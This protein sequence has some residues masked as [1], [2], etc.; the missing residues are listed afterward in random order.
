MEIGINWLDGFYYSF[1]ESNAEYLAWCT[2]NS[3]IPALNATKLEYIPQVFQNLINWVY[4]KPNAATLGGKPLMPIFHGSPLTATEFATLKTKTYNYGG[5]TGVTVPFLMPRWAPMGLAGSDP[6]VQRFWSDPS[7][8]ETHSDGSY[9][10]KPATERPIT[11]AIY[12]AQ[13][14]ERDSK[15]Y[16][17]AHV[18]GML[19]ATNDRVNMAGVMPGFDNKFNAAWGQYA[20]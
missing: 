18:A 9:G 15:E 16:A 2:A 3:K 17:R 20:V 13:G 6:N 10:W 1:I 8:W 4:D 12:K 11:S 7:G 19:K 5:Q 14:D